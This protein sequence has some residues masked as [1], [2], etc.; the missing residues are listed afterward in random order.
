VTRQLLLVSAGGVLGA[1]A[2]Y[3][4][5]SQ[6]PGLWTVLA[7]NV[8]G[9]F[10]LG[11]LIARTEATDWSRPFLGSGVLGG[12]TT[13]STL[14]VQAVDAS[15]GTGIAYVSGTLVLGIGAAD[16]GRRVA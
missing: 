12:F 6:E 15:L 2:R 3:A 10:L 8:L 7:I 16:L 11:V 1:L 9:S 13:M 14:A 4:L 5:T